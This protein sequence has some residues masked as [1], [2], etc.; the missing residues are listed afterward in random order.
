MAAFGAFAAVTVRALS[1][2][3]VAVALLF[4]FVPFV[5]VTPGATAFV[6]FCFL[7]I[8]AGSWGC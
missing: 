2:V 8:F 4:A 7:E 5:F 6:S 3:D 1:R